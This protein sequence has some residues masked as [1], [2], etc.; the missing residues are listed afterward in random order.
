M[1]PYLEPERDGA[2]KIAGY[3][4]GEYRIVRDKNGAEVAVPTFDGA[5]RLLT[6]DGRQAAQPRV[7]A[8]DALKNQIRTEA[9]SLGRE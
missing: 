9:P 3:Q 4:Q 1:S 2:H 8:L 5:A 6:R 7:L